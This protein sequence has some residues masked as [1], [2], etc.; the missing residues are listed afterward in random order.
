MAVA[1]TDAR[2]AKQMALESM[3]RAS[4]NAFITMANMATEVGEAN[5]DHPA[6]ASVPT[7]AGSIGLVGVWNATGSLECTPEFACRL[8]SAMLGTELVSLN[9]DALDAVAEMTNIIFGCM[10]TELERD[11]GLMGMG[12]PTVAYGNHAGTNGV[13]ERSMAIPLCVAG[14]TVWMK[15]NF[16]RSE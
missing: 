8:A 13:S 4:A 14:A 11:L 12:T 5:A 2:A 16:A 10:K 6:G 9:E 15:M 1:D 7:L 3:L